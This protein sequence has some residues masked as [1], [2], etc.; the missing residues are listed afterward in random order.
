[1]TRY[2]GFSGYATTPSLS[3]VSWLD[4]LL[5]F[6]NSI[7]V[8][9]I[10]FMCLLLLC[11][12]LT[13]QLTLQ[14]SIIG[15][16]I[17]GLLAFAPPL[18]INTTVDISNKVASQVYSNKFEYW[19][20][21]QMEQYLGDLKSKIE[22]ADSGNTNDYIAQLM[23]IE[24][25]SV[26]SSIS[27]TGTKLKWMTPK[28]Y[29]D[30]NEVK[31]EID[32]SNVGSTFSSAF[33]NLMINSIAN[34]TSSE[35]YSESVGQTYLY[36]DMC[37]IYLYGMESYHMYK[38][39]WSESD[40][41]LQYDSARISS[42]VNDTSTNN[43]T[44]FIGTLTGTKNLVDSFKNIQTSNNNLYLYLAVNEQKL[45]NNVNSTA[46]VA[47]ADTSSLNAIDRGFLYDTVDVK[48]MAQ[49]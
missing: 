1:M 19:A 28:K 31:T 18:A 12:V 26:S 14:R 41:L 22:A 8:Y 11:Y 23:N 30:L 3:D 45:S 9:F 48:I 36:R 29:N 39:Y 37:D 49:V 33:T 13:G 15:V 46:G 43:K 27:Y 32:N 17:F 6:Y 21:V 24:S 34:S 35:N 7:I 47:I 42:T 20:L 40:S 44:N 25:N 16:V 4:S 5:K 2:L 10:I 38:G